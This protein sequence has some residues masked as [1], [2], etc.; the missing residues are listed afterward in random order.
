MLAEMTC[1]RKDAPTGHPSATVLICTVLITFLIN[2]AENQPPESPPRIAVTGEVT[3]G[4]EAWESS[5]ERDRPIRFVNCTKNIIGTVLESTVHETP[6][7]ESRQ[8]DIEESTS[9][10]SRSITY[11]CRVLR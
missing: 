3:G 11:E 2:T 8:E 4:V 7:T 10:P 6:H 9:S 1:T 5:A